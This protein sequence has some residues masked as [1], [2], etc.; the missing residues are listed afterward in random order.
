[1]RERLVNMQP[2]PDAL[3]LLPATLVEQAVGRTNL[4]Y[5]GTISGIVVEKVSDKSDALRVMLHG[6]KLEPKV[7]FELHEGRW[8]I[9]APV[10][11]SENN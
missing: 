9:T 1:M 6:R 4:I 10:H 5:S 2:H 11:N 3:P 8:I 7:V